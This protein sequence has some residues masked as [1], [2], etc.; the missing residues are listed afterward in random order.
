MTLYF[1][2]DS[3]GMIANITD[4]NDIIYI[5]NEACV[6]D[7][8][9]QSNNGYLGDNTYIMKNDNKHITKINDKYYIQ[10]INNTKIRLLSI[11]YQGG[12]KKLLEENYFHT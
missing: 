5:E 1:L 12:S 4:L 9:I 7:H 6:F 11:H 2:I 8:M 10:T 3:E